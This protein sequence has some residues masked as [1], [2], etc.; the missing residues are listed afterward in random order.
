MGAQ[1][2]ALLDSLLKTVETLAQKAIGKMT[3]P[4]Y[5]ELKKAHKTYLGREQRERYYRQA[6]QALEIS[7]NGIARDSVAQCLDI[8]LKPWNKNQWRFHPWNSTKV[9]AVYEKNKALIVSAR[10]RELPTMTRDDIPWILVVTLGFRNELGSVG[11]A[12][13]LHLLAPRFF[14]L[15][16]R[17]I[18]SK[19]YG[20][21]QDVDPFGYAALMKAV[22]LQWQHVGASWQP[23]DNPLKLIDEWNYCEYTKPDWL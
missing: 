3:K 8:L 10:Q 23:E 6:A 9:Q 5:L 22:K 15:W 7:I 11:A 2:D 20:L 18:A 14:P 1:D 19:G 16:D 17:S 12:K 21:R 4:S 13:A